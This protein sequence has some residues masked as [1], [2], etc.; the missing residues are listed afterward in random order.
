MSAS[1]SVQL[2][3]QCPSNAPSWKRKL[4][5]ARKHF[6]PQI[7][8]ILTILRYVI[9]VEKGL[10]VITCSEHLLGARRQ[11]CGHAREILIGF[12][13]GVHVTQSSTQAQLNAG[14]SAVQSNTARVAVREQVCSRFLWNYRQKIEANIFYAQR[15]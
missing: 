14:E 11:P 13:T 8:P 12:S 15:T 4:Q 1:R 2:P 3:L 7:F 6:P 9:P 10:V 5:A